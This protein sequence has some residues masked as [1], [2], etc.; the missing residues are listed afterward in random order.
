MISYNFGR[1]P[2][3][4]MKSRDVLT[5]V[6][7]SQR[8]AKTVQWLDQVNRQQIVAEQESEGWQERDGFETSLVFASDATQVPS[9][10][11]GQ[12]HVKLLRRHGRQLGAS[13]PGLRASEAEPDAYKSYK[14]K[15]FRC[16]AQ[17]CF[18]TGA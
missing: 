16:F 9:P 8:K 13:P 14:M 10:S 15:K 12:T 18:L 4:G 7:C 1:L 17:L 6:H 11:G 3:V 2:K 5:G